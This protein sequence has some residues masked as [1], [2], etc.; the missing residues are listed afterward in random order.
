MT[1]ASVDVRR[2]SAEHGICGVCC[3]A[4]NMSL[5]WR[6]LPGLISDDYGLLASFLSLHTVIKPCSRRTGK[7]ILPGACSWSVL[8]VDLMN[9]FP[10]RIR[11]AT[12]L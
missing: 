5:H 7:L 8:S 2:N 4:G 10:M 11:S 12:L 3:L 6:I 9:G 1:S